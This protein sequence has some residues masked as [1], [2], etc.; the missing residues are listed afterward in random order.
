MQGTFSPIDILQTALAE[1]SDVYVNA[2][3]D[4]MEYF[5]GLRQDIRKNMCEPFEVSAIVQ[6]PGFQDIPVGSTVTGLCLAHSNAGYW[7]VY[8][9]RLNRFFCFW[10]TKQGSLGAHGVSGSPLRCWSA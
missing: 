1:T 5:E 10:G 2:G 8:Q 4:E 7:L 9:P 6:E 3:I